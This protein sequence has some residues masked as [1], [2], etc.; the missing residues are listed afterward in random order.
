MTTTTSPTPHGPGF[1]FLDELEFVEPGRVARGRKWFDPQWP[2]FADHFPGKP[3]VPG[4]VL[5]ECA[6]QA[7]G[8]LWQQ[9]EQRSTSEAMFLAAVTQFRFHAAVRPAETV[10]SVVTLEKILG[11][12]GLFEVSIQVNGRLVASGKIT[13]ARQLS[14]EKTPAGHG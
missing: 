5:I 8:A 4:V 13:L 14:M 6:A 11:N 1:S 9:A 3:L 10:E 7:A 2:V 12:L